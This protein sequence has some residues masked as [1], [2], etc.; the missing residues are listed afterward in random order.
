MYRI[1]E[2]GKKNGNPDEVELGGRTEEGKKNGAPCKKLKI[3][4]HTTQDHKHYTK[5]T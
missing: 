4:V 3:M 5:S 2:R 1:V